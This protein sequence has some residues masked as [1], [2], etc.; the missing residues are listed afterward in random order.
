MF[1]PTEDISIKSPTAPWLAQTREYVNQGGL[2]RAAI[3]NQ[4]EGCLARLETDYIDLLQVHTF[5]AS[6][7]IEET[8]R[9]LHDLVV[10]GKARYLGACNMKAWQLGE[11]NSIA[12]RNGWTQF[13]SIQIEHSLVFRTQVC[14]ASYRF[15]FF[16]SPTLT[17]ATQEIEMFAYSLY[18]GIGV[19]SYSP[20]LDGNLARPLDTETPRGEALKGTFF[21]KKMRDSDKEIVKRV[22]QI[23]EQRSWTMAAVALTWSSSKV[24]SPI[25]GLNSVSAMLPAAVCGLP[26]P[27]RRSLASPTASSRERP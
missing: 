1:F 11:M 26:E 19:M 14:R 25:V 6:T 3:F 5:D 13:I 16:Y 17:L 4:T 15:W 12:E 27:L 21:E 7:P 24:T 22:E 9:A 2:S 8:M 10:A 20:L 23:A 18:K